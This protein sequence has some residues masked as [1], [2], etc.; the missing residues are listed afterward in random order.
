MFYNIGFSFLD[1]GWQ[2][3]QDFRKLIIHLWEQDICERKKV[4]SLVA[5]C[6]ELRKTGVWEN[7]SLEFVLYLMEI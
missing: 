2:S 1:V 3:K 4:C 5:E 6:Q 7:T